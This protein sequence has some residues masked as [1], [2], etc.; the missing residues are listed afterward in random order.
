MKKMHYRN[1]AIMFGGTSI[2]IPCGTNCHLTRD[3]TKVESNVTCKRCLKF[4]KNRKKP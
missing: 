4:L 1:V 2:T 3:T